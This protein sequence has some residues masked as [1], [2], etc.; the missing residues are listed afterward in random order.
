MLL[1]LFCTACVCVLFSF[2]TMCHKKRRNSWKTDSNRRRWPNLLQSRF[3]TNVETERPKQVAKIQKRQKRQQQK[4]QKNTAHKK[5]KVKMATSSS[6]KW[7]T[8]AATTAATSGSSWLCVVLA[9]YWN[10]LEQ[11]T[12]SRALNA[13]PRRY[14]NLC[15][16]SSRASN[17]NGNSNQQ[18]QS[19]SQRQRRQQS[20]QRSSNS[21]SRCRM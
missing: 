3:E 15:K 20:Q 19:Q 5:G 10:E 13:S 9:R 2:L 21:G 12:C 1:L 8:S 6:C 17:G 14:V 18:R 11:R 16:A 4:I 7:V